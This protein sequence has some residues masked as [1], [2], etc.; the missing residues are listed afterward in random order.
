LEEDILWR[1]A[2]IFTNI[3]VV[4]PT[5]PQ[6]SKQAIIISPVE[7]KKKGIYLAASNVF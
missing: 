5:P 4:I 6:F 3:T 7:I 2:T 1:V